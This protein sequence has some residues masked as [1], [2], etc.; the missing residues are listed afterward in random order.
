MRKTIE[1]YPS[2]KLEFGKWAGRTLREVWKADPSYFTWLAQQRWTWKKYGWRVGR[3]WTEGTL[4][5]RVKTFSPP[6]WYEDL[7]HNRDPE[8]ETMT[9]KEWRSACWELANNYV[10]EEQ[11]EVGDYPLVALYIGDP[12]DD[13]E[14][15]SAE[16]E[17]SDGFAAAIKQISAYWVAPKK[18]EVAERQL[19]EE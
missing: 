10:P 3:Y 6:D 16:L 8:T 19:E 1:Q 9:E 2:I 5:F 15:V 12:S 17:A 7:I 13:A 14:D 4:N 18:V 11:F